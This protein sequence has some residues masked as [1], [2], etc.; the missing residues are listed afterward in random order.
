MFWIAATNAHMYPYEKIP[1]IY[2][3]LTNVTRKR[4]VVCT[5]PFHLSST[6]VSLFR[7]FIVF[8]FQ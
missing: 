4:C 1:V 7:F 6:F 5:E 3:F 2:I 8:F